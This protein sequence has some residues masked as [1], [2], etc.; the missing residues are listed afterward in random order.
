MTKTL[1]TS[2]LVDKKGTNDKLRNWYIDTFSVS[3]DD[4]KLRKIYITNLDIQNAV[5]TV[6]VT[7][8]APYVLPLVPVGRKIAKSSRLA[9]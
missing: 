6:L 3:K 9:I 7:T 4:D 8:F 2:V 1:E 5:G